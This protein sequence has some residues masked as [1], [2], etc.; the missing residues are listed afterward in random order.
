[1]TFNNQPINLP[2][3][4]FPKVDLAP[5]DAAAA[6]KPAGDG[7]GSPDT[8]APHDHAKAKDERKNFGVS[9]AFTAG[10]MRALIEAAWA[11]TQE[12][13]G[14]VAD[15][16]A[17]TAAAAADG[18]GIQR[19]SDPVA[20]AVADE[21]A[22][23]KAIRERIAAVTDKVFSQDI[24][25]ASTNIEGQD[26][27]I[28]VQDN[29]PADQGDMDQ[30]GKAG[31][32]DKVSRETMDALG[33]DPNRPAEV[34]AAIAKAAIATTVARDERKGATRSATEIPGGDATAPAPAAPDPREQ[35]AAAAVKDQRPP[36]DSTGQPDP[37]AQ[38]KALAAKRKDFFTQVAEA[39]KGL[40]DL[41]RKSIS[42][43]A[44]G[45]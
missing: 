36:T 30:L 33:V 2:D 35:T 7:A 39:T 16:A 4:M 34:N 42:D 41:A 10:G 12:A 28:D 13:A 43:I 11:K 17:D 45:K 32:G 31:G 37:Q 19:A 20:D 15:A 38:L 5:T 18:L 21:A 27:F 1:M 22:Q 9:T 24:G 14:A 25:P 23:Q 26:V 40:D 6:T 29:D 44:A 3:S 8:T